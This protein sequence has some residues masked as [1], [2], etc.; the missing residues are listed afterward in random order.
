[1]QQLSSINTHLIFLPR[2]LPP[3]LLL[4]GGRK[5]T[6]HAYDAV[7]WISAREPLAFVAVT[8][9]AGTAI[10]TVGTNGMRR[11]AYCAPI[12][13]IVMGTT[14]TIAITVVI[15]GCCCF[16]DNIVIGGQD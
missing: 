2:F 7:V 15:T 5:V 3:A 16:I 10:S 1:M 8:T 9:V 13:S 11:K 12:M 6:G 4:L 14:A